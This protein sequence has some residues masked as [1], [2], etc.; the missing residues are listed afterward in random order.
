M[1]VD[2][3]LFGEEA[4]ITA[5]ASQEETS[6]EA[7]NDTSSETSSSDEGKSSEEEFEELIKGK[8]S[9]EFKKRVQGIID[10]RFAKMKAYQNTAE[11]VNPILERLYEENPNIEKGDVKGL[12]DAYFAALSK[13]HESPENERLSAVHK[14]ARETVR[15]NNS[16][17]LL[18]SL[19]NEA[20]KVKEIYPSFDLKESLRSSPDMCRLVSLGVGL[21]HAYEVCNLDSI[22]GSAIGYAVKQAG[23]KTAEAIKNSGRVTE[24]S[25]QDRASSVKRTDVKNLTEKEIMK[26]IAE[27]GKGAKITF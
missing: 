21:R 25:L 16:L 17:R 12:V 19:E 13:T 6:S 1:K 4:E 24:N 27:V 10:K 18:G 26:I 8:Y 9:S 2:L 20:Q 14:A 5:A 3:Q 15:K 7:E 22:L 11:A 23:K